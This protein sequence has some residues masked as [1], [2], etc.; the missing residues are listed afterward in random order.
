MAN[1]IEYVLPAKPY[2]KTP[3][4][5]TQEYSFIADFH[6]TETTEESQ[7]MVT[8]LKKNQPENLFQFNKLQIKT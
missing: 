6:S 4:K 8:S 1:Q 5:T 3:N 2:S 7:I